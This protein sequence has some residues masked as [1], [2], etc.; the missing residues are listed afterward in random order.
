MKTID[1][2]K[3]N[4]DRYMTVYQGLMSS[5]NGFTKPE[6]RMMDKVLKKVETVGKVRADGLYEI[7][8]GGSIELE[9][10]EFDFLVAQLDRCRWT[11]NFARRTL[12]TYDYLEGVA[13]GNGAK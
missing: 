8:N 9:D 2:P 1:L 7:Y 10:A 13:K 5:E 4:P 3:D 12:A 6:I 11:P